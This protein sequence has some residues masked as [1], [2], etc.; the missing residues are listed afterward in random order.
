M[1]YSKRQLK[2]GLEIIKNSDLSMDDWHRTCFKLMDE[3]FTVAELKNQ[4]IKY[5]KKEVSIQQKSLIGDFGGAL[6]M[7]YNYMASYLGSQYV[8]DQFLD[9]IDNYLAV[10]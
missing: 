3:G 6:N 9:L 4:V 5:D 7:I 1:K 8:R 2:A 10:L